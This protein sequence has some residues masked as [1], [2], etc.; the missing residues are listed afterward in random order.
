MGREIVGKSHDRRGAVGGLLSIRI[1]KIALAKTRKRGRTG[2]RSVQENGPEGQASKASPLKGESHSSSIRT[3][4]LLIAAGQK[5]FAE[6]KTEFT[7]ALSLDPSFTPAAVDLADLDREL[8]C[9]TEGDRVLRDAIAR[10]PNDAS[11]Q[12]A[13]GLLLVR[14]GH[15]QEAALDRLATA[16]RLDQSN[17]RFVYVYAVALND[18]GHGRLGMP[19]RIQ[20]RQLP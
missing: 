16:A 6:A 8:G 3:M 15:G 11:L 20:L 17:A 13:L 1:L 12:H 18:A 19:Y 10:S 5:R 4:V 7:S 14:Q 2:S 9:E